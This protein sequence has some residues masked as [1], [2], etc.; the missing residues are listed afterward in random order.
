MKKLKYIILVAVLLSIVS[1]AYTQ[2]GSL[3]V[4][5]DKDSIYQDEV[6][7]VEFLLDNLAGN[8]IAPDFSGFRI[9]SG[10]NT[11]SSYS[12]INGHVSQKKSFSYVLVP[13]SAG[14]LLIGRA[15]VESEDG[16]LTSDPLELHVL[17][18]DKLTSTNKNRQRVF[19]YDSDGTSKDTSGKAPSKKRVLKKI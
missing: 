15:V 11:S 5:V 14:D 2:K 18:T 3:S 10:P 19:R 9:V 6:V 12:M 16:N 4:K 7:K 1:F 13:Q 17:E 8:F